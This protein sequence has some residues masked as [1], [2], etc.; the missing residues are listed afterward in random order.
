M[1]GPAP[2]DGVRVLD[3]SRVLA[4]PH[5]GRM[6]ADMGADVIKVE[7]PE[8]DLT[9][10][11]APRVNSLSLYFVQQ[12]CGKRN[13]SL[14]LRRPEAADLLLR[15]AARCDI[16]LENF[17]PG[18]MAKMGLGYEHVAA[19]NPGVVYASLTG[20]GQDGA[21]A[22]R[23]AYAPVVQAE[24]GFVTT[25]HEHYEGPAKTDP[26][27]HADVYT[28]L[29]CLAGILAA[30]YARERTG[31]G[32]QVD[33]AMASTMLS[34]NEHVQRLLSDVDIGEELPLGPGLSPVFDT[35]EGHRIVVSA[36][37]VAKGNFETFCALAGR[38]ELA[39]DP[40]FADLVA[41]KAHR[42]E[43]LAILQEW[44]LGFDDLDEIERTL[45]TR[46][47]AMGVVRDVAEV[48]DSEWAKDRGA[49]VEVSDRG[50]GTVRIPNSPW[51]FSDA[52]SGVRGEPAYRGEHNRQ[53]LD[54]LLGLDGD[55]LDR[56][57]TSGVLSSR[58]PKSAR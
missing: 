4:G 9:R 41:R 54:E 22:G 49:I 11:A 53:V 29:E 20:Y 8:G 23:R 38:P 13:V 1:K 2:L 16:V 12:N 39:E 30:L 25:T 42:H 36:D 56:L 34:V 58:L 10:F 18:V 40:R 57:E 5:C 48:A 55:E 44:L 33:V 3:F 19:R 47:L 6:L 28:G 26:F 21:W 51:R 46:R 17:R 45:G 31:R 37:P 27:S 7:P 24:M 32:Q 52:D 15:L 50:G 43:L 14:D 35:V